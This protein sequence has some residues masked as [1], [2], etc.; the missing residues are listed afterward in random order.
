M[1]KLKCLCFQDI[2][3]FINR[4]IF[5]TI[6]TIL[7]TCSKFEKIVTVVKKTLNLRN[8]FHMEEVFLQNII[9]KK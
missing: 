4:F 1:K 6:Y 3:Y 8:I 5:I 2:R 9:F 7:F